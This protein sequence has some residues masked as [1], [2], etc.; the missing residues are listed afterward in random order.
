MAN[1]SG[2]LSVTI[3]NGAA[4]SSTFSLGIRQWGCFQIPAA[5]TGATVTVKGSLDGTTFTTILPTNSDNTQTVA[6]NG[7]YQLPLNAVNFPYLQLV[8]ASNE[9]AA[10]TINIFLRG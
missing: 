6:A 3:A 1:S 2:T 8:S 9:A 4:T 7:T 10:R 5:F